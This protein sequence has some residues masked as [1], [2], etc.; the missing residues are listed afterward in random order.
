MILAGAGL[1]DVGQ[2]RAINEDAFFFDDS[3]GLY[4]VADGMGGHAAGEVASAEAVD[5]VRGMVRNGR[6]ALDRPGR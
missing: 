3:I 5:T 1:T 6:P 4:I 2:R